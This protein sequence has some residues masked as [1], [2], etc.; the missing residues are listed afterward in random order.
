MKDF[1]CTGELVKAV[2]LKGEVKL[3]PLLDHF[4]ELLDSPYVVWSDGSA[5]PVKRYRQAGSCLA[6]KFEGVNSRNDAEA[7]VGRK[8]G[9]IKP[10]YLE[11]DFPKPRQG[12][13]FRFVG[14]E[15]RTKDGL[16]IG[17]V[18]EVRVGGGQY[19]LVIPDPEDSKLEILIP[20]VEPILQK[21]D[22]IEGDLI[23]DPPEGLLDVQSD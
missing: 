8:L 17:T 21:D 5:V 10:Q 4:D 13:A 16:Q 3:Y 20:A 6:V 19:L 15:V 23:I 1:V 7:M 12:L 9:F 22:S 18:S 11:A 14:R 2:G